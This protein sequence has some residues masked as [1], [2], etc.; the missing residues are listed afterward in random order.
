MRQYNVLSL[1][2]FPKDLL[3]CVAA[4]DYINDIGYDSTC[5]RLCS[6][7]STVEH[8]LSGIITVYKNPVINV[9]YRIQW[10]AFMYQARS[11]TLNDLAVFG[12]STT[13]KLYL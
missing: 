1:C 9:R 13:D 4:Y 7:T 12:P 6:R 11:Y 10:I 8:D 5:S 3:V 2:F